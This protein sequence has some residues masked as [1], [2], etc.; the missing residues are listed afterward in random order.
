M[1]IAA[2][3]DTHEKHNYIT[4]FPDADVFVFAG[5][6]TMIGDLYWIADFNKENIWKK[7]VQHAK[8]EG[9]LL[10]EPKDIGYLIHAVK[11]DFGIENH[12]EVKKKLSKAFYSEI[13]RGIMNG[14]PEWYKAELMKGVLDENH[15]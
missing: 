13:E 6:A 12:E 5:D 9:K 10:G 1:K 11:K 2:I 15:T 3:S 4:N 7:A 8:E 14:F